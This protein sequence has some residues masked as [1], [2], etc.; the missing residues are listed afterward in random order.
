MD[1]RHFRS[2][3][4]TDIIIQDYID[5]HFPNQNNKGI[6]V[7]VGAYDG[8]DISNT[9]YLE[10]V[11]GWTGVL[12]EPIPEKYNLAKHNRWCD[13]FQGCI[14]NKNGFEDFQHIKGYSEMISNINSA[15]HPSYLDRIKREIDQHNQ[16]IINIKVPCLTLNS[17]LDC[18]NITKADY[19][20]L[21]TITSELKVLQA[22]NVNDNPI[23]IISLDFNNINTD[24]L[25]KWFQENGY[26]QLWKNDKVD[27]YIFINDDIK[28][29]WQ[30]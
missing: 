8:V 9:Y 15:C 29:T 13:V 17:L 12:V 6:F 11:K 23:K 24:E 3:W 21:D 10:K 7:E 14:F 25:K 16:E 22:Y 28:F 20:S 5:Q 19:L 2:Q 26:R 4:G 18:Y 30:K 1:T 27:E